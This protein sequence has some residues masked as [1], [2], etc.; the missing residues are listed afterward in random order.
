MNQAISAVG[1]I[2]LISEVDALHH[3]RQFVKP[4]G[5]LTKHL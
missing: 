1:T 3:H 5:S 4:I 2:Q